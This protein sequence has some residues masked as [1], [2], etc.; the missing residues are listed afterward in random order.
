MTT[1]RAWNA[2]LAIATCGYA[3]VD[4][5]PEILSEELLGKPGARA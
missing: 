5:V 2:H 1:G 3:E 4:G